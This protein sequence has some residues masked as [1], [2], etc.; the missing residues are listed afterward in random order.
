MFIMLLGMITLLI[1]FTPRLINGEASSEVKTEQ[2]TVEQRKVSSGNHYTIFHKKGCRMHFVVDRPRKEDKN[3]ML[4]IPAAFTDLN[5]YGVDGA[6]LSNGNRCNDQ[7]N[8]TLGGALKIENGNSFIFSTDKG[9]LLTDSLLDAIAKRKGS[10]F[11]QIYMV[12]DGK[13][14]SFKDKKLF[15]R[16]GLV[17]MKDK[18]WAVIESLEAISLA[19]FSND[20]VEMGVQHA[21]Y[22][23]M[24][25]WD[26]G[27]YREPGKEKVNV[28]GQLRSQTSRQ[29][30]WVIFKAE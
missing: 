24:G 12:V 6:C 8:Y 26:E 16:R 15:Q 19:D 17:Q 11:Q 30:N 3:I 28:I 21:L 1:V 13:A 5:D 27:W 25:A 4:C 20:L 18:S 14:E 7:V 10:L 29:S 23:D 2:I 22:T 9:R